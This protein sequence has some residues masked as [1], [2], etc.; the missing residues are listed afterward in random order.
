MNQQYTLYQIKLH[1]IFMLL[2]ADRNQGIYRETKATYNKFIK[3]RSFF[4][5]RLFVVWVKD[6]TF[7]VLN[8]RHSYTPM[9]GIA[10]WGK[11]MKFGQREQFFSL[12][13]T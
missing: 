13:G 11:Y 3:L 2:T 7:L 1:Q 5:R 12:I 8:I 9:F 6:M 4:R 10:N